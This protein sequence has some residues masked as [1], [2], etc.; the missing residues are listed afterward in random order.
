MLQHAMPD[1]AADDSQDDDLALAKLL[2]E[3]EQM[4]LRLRS[5]LQTRNIPDL[6]HAPP[7]AYS[8]AG[9]HA[10]DTVSTSSTESIG[11]SMAN[12]FQ[13]LQSSTASGSLAS[14]G[15]AAASP[16][17]G[18]SEHDADME[19]ARKL[20]EEEDR[21]HY[22]RMLQMAGIGTANDDAYLSD[23]SVDPDDMTYEQLRALGDTVGVVSRGAA[24]HVVEGLHKMSYA[25][26]QPD[27]EKDSCTEQCTVCCMEF[28]K[29]DEACPICHKEVAA[30][31][32]I[33]P[34]ATVKPG[35]AHRLQRKAATKA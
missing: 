26:H 12:R 3:Q 8:A 25:Q 14:D 17:E 27:H 23:D 15:E 7:E 31:N 20:Q 19:F 9:P 5:N 28:E 6:G 32:S 11:A 4:F 16:S 22:E 10:P 29:E 2:Q 33:E 13:A 18:G 30:A 34:S 24:Q 1:S 21:I 35:S